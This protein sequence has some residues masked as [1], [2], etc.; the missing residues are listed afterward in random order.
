[1]SD[2]IQITVAVNSEE[3]AHTIAEVLVEKRLAASCWVSG[4]I[5]SRYWWKGAVEKAQE[6][7]CTAK[8]RAD[9]YSEVEHAIKGMHPYEEPGIL[10]IPVEAGSQTYFEWIARETRAHSQHDQTRTSKELLIQELIEAHEKLI[11]VATA[12]YKRGARRTS[13]AWG[14][15]EILAHVAGWEAMAVSRIPRIVAGIP[16]IT[17]ATEAQHAAMDDAINATVLT[18]IGDQPFDAIC[19]ILRKTYQTDAQIISELDVA[20]TGPGSYVYE[21]TKAAINH[22]REHIQALG[23]LS[24][25]NEE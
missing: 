7:V 18:M 24:F 6:W 10:A 8:T 20:S 2:F 9:L 1:M 17:Y 4:P 13:D 11:E 21:R 14:P 16:P 15:R 25:S 19:T 22:C 23:Q 5:T 12:A 3:S